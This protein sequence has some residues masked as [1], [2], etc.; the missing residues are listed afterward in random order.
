MSK[1]Q[2]TT[3]APQGVDLATLAAHIK[4]FM[5]GYGRHDAQSLVELANYPQW[6]AIA[7]H[8]LE[9]RAKAKILRFAALLGEEELQAVICGRLDIGA[10]AAEVRSELKG[11]A[12]K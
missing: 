10:L 3:E 11:G 8:E 12:R 5:R 1:N 7:Q 9:I 6:Q 4:D 2:Q